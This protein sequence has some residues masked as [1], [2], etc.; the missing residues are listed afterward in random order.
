MNFAHPQM[1]HVLTIGG[2]VVSTLVIEQPQFFRSLLHDIDEQ[3][4]GVEGRSV[5]SR[6][7][8]VLPFDKNAE[9]I[10]D[11]LHFKLGQKAL[12]TKLTNRLEHIAMEEEHYYQTAQLL[13]EVEKYISDLAM[14]LPCDVC[15]SKI[16]INGIL[17]AVGVDIMDDHESDLELLLDYMELSRELDHQQLF[18]LVNLR[19]YYSDAEVEAFFASALAHEFLILPVDSVSR[20]HLKNEQRVTIDDDLC[21]F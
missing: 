15:C 2:S 20:E 13:G 19:S 17:R 1:D 3:I 8:V 12:L 5:L 9:L 18:I 14:D 4:N 16:S 11:F 21:E 7:G 10:E 6:D